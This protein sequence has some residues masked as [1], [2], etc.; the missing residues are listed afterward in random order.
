MLSLVVHLTVQPDNREAF[1]HAI[2][3]NAEAA[4]RDEPGCSRFDV[5]A[6]GED[7]T[8]FLLYETYDDYAAF[9][10]HRAS[11]H[12]AAWRAA[13]VDVVVPGSQVTTFWDVVVANPSSKEA[14]L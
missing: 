12:F 10:A 7:P 4:M 3:C 1:L 13:S 2:P 9:E 5:V 8:R 11:P 6:S 14:R